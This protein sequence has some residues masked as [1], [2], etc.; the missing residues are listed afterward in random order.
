MDDEKAKT[1]SSFSS[2]RDGDKL[3]ELENKATEIRKELLGSLL[4]A[5][6]ISK[7]KIEDSPAGIE[8]MKAIEEAE[9]AFVSSTLTDRFEKLYDVLAVIH[10]RTKAIF[11]LMEHISKNK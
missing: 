11:R 6:S 9:D 3:V 7:E 10:K 5:K 8:V 2:I 4:L 1:T